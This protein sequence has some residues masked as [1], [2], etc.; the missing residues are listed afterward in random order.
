VVLVDTNILLRS[1]PSDPHYR[2]VTQALAALKQN[3]E[4]LCIAPQNLVEYWVV[5][6]RPAANNGLGM[7]AVAA[8]A[9]VHRLRGTFRVLEGLPGITDTW[10]TLVGKHQILGKQAHDA[11][12]VAVMQVNSVASILT[13]NRRD[14]Q[15][16]PGI[17]V[18]DPT[19]V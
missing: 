8:L 4:T 18:L 19:Q 1:H 10:E 6:T 2:A 11:H 12:L 13:F 16:Y 9:E 7:S 15:R 3:G 5:A 14:F 17:T